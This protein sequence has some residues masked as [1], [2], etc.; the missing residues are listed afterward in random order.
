[1]NNLYFFQPQYTAKI[2]D[3]Y[4]YWLPYSVGCLWAY[5]QQFEDIKKNWSV[6]KKFYK[7]DPI[8]QVL[9]NLD[10]PAV[11]AFSCYCWNEQYNLQIAKIIKDKW[12]NTVIVFGGPQT[13]SNHLKHEFI[14]A[15]IFGEGEESFLEILR[16]VDKGKKP[17][18]FYTKKRLE[19]LDIPSPY[20]IGF[21]DD[22]IAEAEPGVYFQ[23]ILETNRG[24]PYSCTFCDWGSTT[25]GKVKKFDLTRIEGEIK[26]ITSNPITTLFIADANFG[27]F[28][29]RDHQIAKMLSAYS[30]GSK[31]EYLNIT[32]AK[33]SNENVFRIAK[34]LGSLQRGVTLSVQSMNPDT[35]K[36]IKRDNMASNDLKKMYALA[37]KYELSTYT[38]MILGLP[39]E[40]YQSF[41]DGLCEILE[42]GQHTQCEMYLANLMENTELNKIQ[43]LQYSIKT[44]R[45]ENYQPFSFL[46][47][48]G[49]P[50]YTDLVCETNTMSKDD[51]A[52]A[53]MFHW[54]LQNFHWL[55]Y[56]Q[57]LAKYSRFTLGVSYK[58]YYEKFLE[59]L[60]NDQGEL[61]NEFRRIHGLVRNLMDTGSLGVDTP[62]HTLNGV[63]MSMIYSNIEQALEL[64]KQ[65]TEYFGELD[66]TV[67]EIQKR[68]VYN[69]YYPPVDIL[70]SNYDIDTWEKVN[71]PYKIE[72]Q[73]K[74]FKSTSQ[75]IWLLRR[76]GKI[77]NK[78]INL[79]ESLVIS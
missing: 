71:T 28:K 47:Q 75:G 14:D 32:Y 55:G 66:Q 73:I 60:Q 20:L 48:S 34:S 78:I 49:I 45:S 31:L 70:D 63:S 42:L 26:W 76:S 8:E 69:D 67:L 25:Y 51:M 58:E 12:P 41:V 33:M 53:F 72:C 65:C 46:D 30:K 50:E 7:R 16:T 23:S 59:L 1:M 64:S 18:Q 54:M 10:N 27:I 74:N 13:G 3:I 62:I 21:F 17:E 39:D 5:A 24:C 4:Q 44:V 6:G 37:H 36:A 38:E 40:T 19:N 29:E 79:S 2:G 22:I 15:I 77:K 61:G 57:I 52:D 9:A 11:C 68:F 35:L 43:K 56:S